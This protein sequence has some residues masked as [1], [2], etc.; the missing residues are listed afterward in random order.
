MSRQ[1]DRLSAH[2][3]F[4]TA[5][6]SPGK[7]SELEGMSHC[8]L[9]LSAP[10]LSFRPDRGGTASGDSSAQSP[11]GKPYPLSGSTLHSTL[12]K[13][14]IPELSTASLAAVGAENIRDYFACSAARQSDLSNR[15]RFVRR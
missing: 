13:T 12:T 3:H 10:D 8:V 14:D 1:L 4:H 5:R 7:L 9:V 11:Q 2:F 6:P 15:R